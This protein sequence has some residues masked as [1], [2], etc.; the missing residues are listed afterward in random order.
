M[1]NRLLNWVR[2]LAL[3][4][5][6]AVMVYAAFRLAAELQRMRDVRTPPEGDLPLGACAL[7]AVTVIACI[8]AVFVFF[9]LYI[10]RRGLARIASS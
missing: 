9:K 4:S 10:R 2:I 1:A 7:Q 5:A 6:D 3:A 8:I